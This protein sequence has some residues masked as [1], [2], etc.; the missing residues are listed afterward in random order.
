MARKQ[1]YT[2]E[3]VQEQIFKNEWKVG[4]Y[5]RLSREDGDKAESDS[6][7]NQKK[8]LS[9]YV[10]EHEEFVDF[11]YFIDEDETGTN[12]N[13]PA[14]QQMINKIKDNSIN[15]IVIKD[16]SRLGRDYIGVGKYIEH[17]LPQYNCRFI[18]I[19]DRLD[20]YK[21]PNEINSLI[22]RVKSLAHDKNSQDISKKVRA[23][24]NMQRR[25]GKYISPLAPFGYKKDPNNKYKLIIDEEAA[26]IVRKI[27]DWY[28]EGYGMVRIAQRLNMLGIM[29]R[30]DYRKYG[31]LYYSDDTVRDNCGWKPNAISDIITNKAYIGAVVQRKRTTRDYKNRK[32]IY[33]EEKDYIIVYD[34][35]EPIIDKKKFSKVQELLKSKCV[36]TCNRDEKV[37]LFSGLLRCEDCKS[38]M[39][40]NSTFQ[41]GKW[42]TYYKCKSYNQRGSVICRFSHSIKHEQIYS[43]VL[44]SI[45]AQIQ[46]L[47]NIKRVIEQINQSKS[48]QKHS[49]NYDKLISKKQNE[50]ERLKLLKVSI[51]SDWKL[52]VLSKQEYLFTKKTYDTQTE[53]IKTEIE[54]LI[55]EKKIDEDIRNNQFQWLENIVK[56]GYIK[57]LNR[58]IILLFIDNIYI[59]KDKNIKI[60]FK[61][62][63]QFNK[64]LTYAENHVNDSY[65]NIGGSYAAK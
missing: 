59:T 5:I 42:Y 2:D 62:H 61:H 34:M 41:K 28:L 7:V 39:I 35:H 37:H 51:Y 54:A 17:I 48:I 19:I 46:S 1:F 25:E 4:L 16:L 31:S 43:I 38:P 40:R 65:T 8:L 6:V 20:S 11:D 45:N 27:F 50:I 9:R 10:E 49:L 64:L 60:V 23:T 52:D 26:G 14:F 32:A 33:L 58:E 44:A 13:R 29:I 24:K 3:Q 12:F 18:S 63:D 56:G 36:K 53:K 57:S 55:S 47:V 21:N 15:C 22:V 30:K